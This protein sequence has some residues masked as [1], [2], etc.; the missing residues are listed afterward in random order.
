MCCRAE[1]VDLMHSSCC[2]YRE[3]SAKVIVLHCDGTGDEACAAETVFDM[4]SRYESIHSDAPK[5]VLKSV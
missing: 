3:R 1:M 4:L 5:Q 2:H